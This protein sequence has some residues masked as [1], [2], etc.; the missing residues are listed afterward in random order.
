MPEK[1][2]AEQLN[3]LIEELDGEAV[4][5]DAYGAI[6]FAHNIYLNGHCLGCGKEL[7]EW[8]MKQNLRKQT[9]E[10]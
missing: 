8:G 6:C 5:V 3:N 7:N 10:K 4:V 2:T 1:L 9:R